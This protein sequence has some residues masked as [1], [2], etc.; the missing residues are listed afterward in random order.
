MDLSGREWHETEFMDEQAKRPAV[1]LDRD[2]TITEEVGYINHLSRLKMIPGA[3]QAV[4]RLND[5]GVLAILTSNQ[6]GVARGYATEELLA[7][8]M[9]RMEQLLEQESGAKLDAVHYCI[10]HPGGKPPYNQDSRDRKPKPGM[11]EKAC[12]KFPI[13]LTRSYVVGDR[14]HD[15]AFGKSLGLKSVLVLTGYGIGE[16]EHQREDFEQLPDFVAL[17]LEAAVDW[18]LTDLRHS[19]AGTAR[20][21][22]RA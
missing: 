14:K 18:I 8:T 15:V 2:G 4:K 22:S 13:D 3:A 16:W 19:N 20:Q 9:T 21:V 17:D 1:F 5:A 10:F 6:A 11:V 12:E 7:A